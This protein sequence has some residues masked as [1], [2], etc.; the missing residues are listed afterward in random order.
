MSSFLGAFGDGLSVQS[1]SHRRASS[2][3]R[4]KRRRSRSRSRS[5]SRNRGGSFVG[6][7][8]GADSNYTRHNSSKS[9][10]FGMGNSSRSSFFPFGG[11]SS[12]Y[13]RSP[14]S[15]FMQRSYKQLKRLIR[16]LIHWAKRHPVKVF[17]LVIMPL[18]TGGALTALLARFGLRLP[19]SLERMLGMAARASGGGSFGA[20]SGAA[21]MAGDYA[22]GHRGSYGGGY[23][24]GYGHS[25]YG[26]GG[27]RGGQGW[28]QSI[29]GVAKMFL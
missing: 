5:S 25:S 28:E 11:R 3:S 6:G 21:R 4:P 24:G 14:R 9:N 7:L 10:F 19:P 1:S 8:F 2:R 13:K 29:M 27:S 15:G 23:G 18:I 17:M 16:D 12:Y 26:G 22:S 20:M